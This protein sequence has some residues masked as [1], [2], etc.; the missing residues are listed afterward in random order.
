MRIQLK[1]FPVNKPPFPPVLMLV[2]A[3]PFQLAMILVK[4]LP[5]QLAI[6]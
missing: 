5:F 6:A 4:A 3:L 2:K 1:A